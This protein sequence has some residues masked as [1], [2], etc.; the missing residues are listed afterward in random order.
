MNR[1][2]KEGQKGR[3]EDRAIERVSSQFTGF[4]SCFQLIV[5]A[6]GIKDEM[7]SVIR[8][9][10]GRTRGWFSVGVCVRVLCLRVCLFFMEHFTVSA[11]FCKVTSVIAKFM[12]FC[13]SCTCRYIYRRR[14]ST[15]SPTEYHK[16][17]F[18]SSFFFSICSDDSAQGAD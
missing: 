2:R 13:L 14:F 18:R 1:V 17:T 12:D 3:K 6:K 11:S 16:F 4:L 7:N 15:L 9:E 5:S 8:G 10:R